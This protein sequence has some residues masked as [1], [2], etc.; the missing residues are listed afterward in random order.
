MHMIGRER[1]VIIDYH[2]RC[3]SHVCHIFRIY[4]GACHLPCILKCADNLKGSILVQGPNEVEVFLRFWSHFLIIVLF[5]YL[6]LMI[7]IC[8][9]VTGVHKI[10]RLDKEYV[11]ILRVVVVAAS[12]CAVI[13]GM[14][15][16]TRLWH[17]RE[18]LH[19]Q[20]WTRGLTSCIS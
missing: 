5:S 18:N 1:K 13:R 9:P 11:P 17:A 3:W 7:W 19:W 14:S 8:F 15:K 10:A 4:R 20:G 6:I 2:Q 16:S 12:R